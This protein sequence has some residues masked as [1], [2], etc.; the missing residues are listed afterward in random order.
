MSDLGTVS[1]A[2]GIE[3][4]IMGVWNS[5]AALVAQVPVLRLI[6]GRIPQSELM[7]YV[8]MEQTGGSGST[9]T[10]KS[11]YQTAKVAFHVWT[12]NYAAGNAI[13]QLILNAFANKGFDWAS[14][15]VLDMR[16]DGP[17]VN[18]QTIMPEVKL[19][20][21]TLSFVLTTWQGRQD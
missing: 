2:T 16:A 15:G 17:P 7:P 19:W 1:G 18:Q 4:A 3:S 13:G 8:R 20:E 11:C 5:N 6:T 10:N 14:G 12:E 9:R 21:T